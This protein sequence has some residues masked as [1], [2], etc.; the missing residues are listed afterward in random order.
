MKLSHS[1]EITFSIDWISIDTM[2]E[3]Y[4]CRSL[5]YLM[6]RE[7]VLLILMTSLD[8]SMSSTQTQR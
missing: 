8:L 1:C 7:R 5:I 6:S 2:S 4:T 3:I